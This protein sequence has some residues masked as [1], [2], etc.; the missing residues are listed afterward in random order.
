MAYRMQGQARCYA[1]HLHA[2]NINFDGHMIG[3]R[4]LR[5][6]LVD[7]KEQL[8]LKYPLRV[9]SLTDSVCVSLSVELRLADSLLNSV[10]AQYP[11][12]TCAPRLIHMIPNATATNTE[13][14]EDVS[15]HLRIAQTLDD[16]STPEPS[17]SVEL[18]AADDELVSRWAQENACDM[19]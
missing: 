9:I 7:G 4:M 6:R 13:H 2:C 8:E 15:W 11:R 10:T 16:D 14:G 19:Q 1:E 17:Y 12:G 5:C 3:G 18:E